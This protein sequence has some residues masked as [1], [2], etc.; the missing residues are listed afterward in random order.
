MYWPNISEDIKSIVNKCEKC[1]ANCCHNQK[2]P[3]IPF[4][5]PIVAWKTVTTDQ[6]VFQGKT[7]IV[8]MDLFSRFPVVSQLHGES[9]KL[10]LNALKDVFS[11]FG[12]PE[13][14][15]SNNGPCY[16]SQEFNDF[17]AKFDIVHQTGASHNYQANSI[18]ECAIQTI[19][20]L[21]IKIKMIHGWH[22]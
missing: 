16:K 19:K 14:I 10:V 3:Y 5:I 7:C 21:M 17:S 18:T 22:Y 6:L 8:V 20:H 11:H 12:I 4:D 13:I 9:M 2:E 15:T 1:L